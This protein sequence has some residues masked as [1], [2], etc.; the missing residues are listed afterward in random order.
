MSDEIYK[1]DSEDEYQFTD[2]EAAVVYK[3]D[4]K[5]PV[6][7]I[8]GQR[9]LWLGLAILIVGIVLY[10]LSSLFIGNKANKFPDKLAALPK[11]E[12]PATVPAQT[13]MET[14]VA[15]VSQSNNNPFQLDKRLADME[16]HN[17]EDSARLNR[18]ETQLNSVNR[19]FSQLKMQMSQ[20]QNELRAVNGQISNLQQT[21][22]KPV[23]QKAPVK[24][25]KKPA[26]P[27]V[28]H[29]PQYHVQAVLPGRAWLVKDEDMSTMTVAVGDILP[30]Y[31]TIVSINPI[32]ASV[33]TSSGYTIPYK[34]D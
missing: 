14:P 2:N 23:E 4:K 8:L 15:P 6:K 10:K 30:G 9:R 20:L 31:G 21:L 1:P 13:S 3:A 33:I 12:Q 28:V 22:A 11:I 25:I 17:Q 18:L 24:L 32:R 29:R 27:I 26:A 7:N 5:N 19:D 34:P 16:Q